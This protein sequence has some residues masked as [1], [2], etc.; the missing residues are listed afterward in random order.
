VVPAASKTARLGLTV[1]LIVSALLAARGAHATG[2]T[3]AAESAPPPEFTEPSFGPRYVIEAIEVMGNQK[4]ESSLIVRATGLRTGDTVDAADPRVEAARLRLLALGYFLDARLSV[5]R[6]SKRGSAVLRVEVEER[7]TIVINE[8]FPSTSAA[9]A[10][11]GGGDASET[12]FLGRGISL[13]AGFVASTHPLVQNA[14]NGLG[15]RLH[16]AVPELRGPGGIGVSATGLYSDG[17]EFYRDSGQDS[18]PDPGRFVA[19][20]TRRAGGVIG[21]GKTLT[22]ALHGTAD[23]R[24][25]VVSTN[26]PGLRTRTL[27]DGT[28]VPIDFMIREGASRVGTLALG[29][30]Y[31]TRSDPVLPRSGMRVLASLEGAAGLLGSSYQYLKGVAQGSFY[32]PMPRGHAIGLHLFVGAIAGDAPYFDRFFVGD[33]N[34]LLARR[35]LGINFSTQPSRNLLGTT[36]ARHRYD[37][38]A[39]R[40]LVDY[41]VPIWRRHGF[42]YGGDAF[43]AFGIFGQASDGDLDPPGPFSLS[44]LPID[45]TADLGLR[46]DTYVGIFTISIANA[47][48][49]SSF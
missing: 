35:A 28:T 40:V 27:L 10:F 9:T 32:H 23:L 42:V 2:A 13:G 11:W 5:R 49:R 16:G 22:P 48:S 19:V 45:L 30:D 7:G 37:N 4:T 12:N 6:G 14:D 8:L 46:L 39:A 38:Y 34:L 15:L 41:A 24:E 3:E 18:D 43:A 26:F 44:Q 20:Q 36:I 1:L 21:V 31:D 17:S 29:I 25:E 47:L 33:L